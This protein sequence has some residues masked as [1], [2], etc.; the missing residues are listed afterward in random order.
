MTNWHHGDEP[1]AFIPRDPD[2]RPY[3]FAPC[4]GGGCFVPR[5]G[6]DPARRQAI[7]DRAASWYGL[8]ADGNLIGQV[9]IRLD[10]GVI[11][12]DLLKFRR[13]MSKPTRWQR[14]KRALRRW[15]P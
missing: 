2:N 6:A 13:P 5:L 9:E 15:L 10:G 14:I 12:D 4:D 11:Y 3:S 8:S 1:E 7:L